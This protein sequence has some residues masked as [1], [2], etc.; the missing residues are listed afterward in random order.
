MRLNF[1][2]W[3]FDVDHLNSQVAIPIIY[4]NCIIIYA[5]VYINYKIGK[6][7]DCLIITNICG[8]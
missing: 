6:Y 5:C 7:V 1:D 8:C 4:K 3:H 2:C